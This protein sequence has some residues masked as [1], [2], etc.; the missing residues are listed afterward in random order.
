MVKL[1]LETFITTSN[2]VHDNKFNY[3]LVEY[4]NGNEK[5]KIICPIHDEFEQK[6][7]IHIKGSGC[8]ACAKIVIQKG[9][10]KITKSQ[11]NFI[12]QANEI[13]NNKFDYSQSKYVNS[14]TKIIIICPIHGEFEQP[15]HAHLRGQT[16][17]QCGIYKK[18]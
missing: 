15:T 7:S 16:C 17:F 11:D 6:P 18:N 2:K 4:K 12:E 10:I 9:K 8:I 1:T 3:D 5:V 13:H 14:E